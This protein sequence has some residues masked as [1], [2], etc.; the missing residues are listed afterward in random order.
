MEAPSFTPLGPP[1]S[2]PR[3]SPLATASAAAA[4]AAADGVKDAPLA[5]AKLGSAG[6][7][8]PPTTV[9]TGRPSTAFRML[10]FSWMGRGGRSK[11]GLVQ[12]EA[13]CRR[14][15]WWGEEAWP[16]AGTSSMCVASQ[17]RPHSP[18][19]WTRTRGCCSPCTAW[20][21]S[22]PSRSGCQSTPACEWIVWWVQQRFNITRDL[23]SAS[24]HAPWV[25]GRGR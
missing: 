18:R 12:L 5:W 25:H 13:Y 21:L 9:P 2:L 3:G 10:P 16:R 17:A 14:P 22:R 7:S 15:P 24:K 19:G 4:A 11:A 6:E 20:L 8:S 23:T 1:N